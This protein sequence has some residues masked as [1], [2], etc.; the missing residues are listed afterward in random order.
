MPM[1]QFVVENIE[2]HI[3]LMNFNILL[4]ISLTLICSTNDKKN[5]SDI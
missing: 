4:G 2:M 5:F 1:D 3:E